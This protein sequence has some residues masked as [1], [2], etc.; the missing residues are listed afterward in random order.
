MA[1][2]RAVCLQPGRVNSRVV[3]TAECL[4][5]DIHVFV[6]PSLSASK[7]ARTLNH[8]VSDSLH[9]ARDERARIITW[10]QYRLP[11]RGIL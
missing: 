7:A 9:A 8:Q 5:R 4:R 2:V 1:I 10:R 6:S 3:F 11:S